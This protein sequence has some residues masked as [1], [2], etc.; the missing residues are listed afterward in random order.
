MARKSKK[1]PSCSV[2]ELLDRS[3]EQTVRRFVKTLVCGAWKDVFD[4]YEDQDEDDDRREH[5]VIDNDDDEDY[6][7]MDENDP[8]QRAK[9]EKYLKYI[10]DAMRLWGRATRKRAGL[11]FMTAIVT[12][13]PSPSSPEQTGTGGRTA[14]AAPKPSAYLQF[15]KETRPLLKDESP[16]IDFVE[17]AKELGRRW[18]ALTDEEK[19]RYRPSASAPPAPPATPAAPE[20]PSLLGTMPEEESSTIITGHTGRAPPPIRFE[21]N[22]EDHLVDYND[23]DSE[24]EDDDIP[25][26]TST[27]TD[28]PEP[29]EVVIR[30]D[31]FAILLK[32]MSTD[33]KKAFKRYKDLDYNQLLDELDYNNIFVVESTPPTPQKRREII[34]ALMNTTFVD[35]RSERR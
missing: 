2:L 16:G 31:Y 33:E 34:N 19:S 6:T 27:Q 5:D 35:T 13:S 24:E 14:R 4:R 12:P 26:P 3:V 11:S 7:E 9:I 22:L 15:C 32:N 21:D 18:R 25:P 30:K 10:D 17:T 20:S 28:R 8:D 23:R 1:I 29:R